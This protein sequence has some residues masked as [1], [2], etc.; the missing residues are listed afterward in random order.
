[1]LKTTQSELDMVTKDPEQF[2]QLALDTCD[3]QRSKVVKT[4]AAKLIDTLCD[5]IDGSLSFITLFCCQAISIAL[6]GEN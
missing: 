5:N 6:E 3:K 1:M 4:Q 2:V